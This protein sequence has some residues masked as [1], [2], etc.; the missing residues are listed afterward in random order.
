MVDFIADIHGN[1]KDIREVPAISEAREP[2]SGQSIDWN[3]IR[4]SSRGEPP[5]LVWKYM[6]DPEFLERR[7]EVPELTELLAEA[8][9]VGVARFIEL[10][11]P[12]PE[13]LYTLVY[14]PQSIKVNAVEGASSL[15]DSLHQEVHTGARG[16]HE[17]QPF[18]PGHAWRRSVVLEL[19]SEL[20]PPLLRNWAAVR[21][22]SV[23]AGYVLRG[24]GDGIAYRHRLADHECR[25]EVEWHNPGEY[26]ASQLALI[27]AYVRLL[28]SLDLD[29]KW[30]FP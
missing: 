15:W 19:P 8:G 25:S 24:S 7:Y 14:C 29:P 27:D 17:G 28:R 30:R 13:R 10:P 4:E 5:G 20:C 16:I 1:V 12:A 9:V 6:F 18:D 22:A 23:K 2:C 26:D 11:Y 3:A 21:E